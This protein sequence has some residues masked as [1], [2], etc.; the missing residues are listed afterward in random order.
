MHQAFAVK[1]APASVAPFAFRLLLFSVALFDPGRPASATDC[2][3]GHISERVTIARVYDGD[4]VRL[5]DGR[6]L[7]IIGINTPE[8]SRPGQAGE[9]FATEARTVLKQLLDSHNHTL[10]LQYGKE[11]QDHYGRQLAHAFLESGENIA[12]ALLRQGLATTLVVPPNTWGESCYLKLEEAAR[13]ARRGLWGL[14]AYQTTAGRTLSRDT[15]GFRL[16]RG[17]VNEIRYSPRAVWIDIEGPLVIRVAREDLV[18]FS[19]D[20]PENLNGRSIE[21]RGWIKQDRNGLRINVRHPAAMVT[22]A[23]VTVNH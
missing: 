12:V 10:L 21:V 16:I 19:P 17:S 2:P 3:A 14:A 5:A 7:R 11:R 15:R 4:T 6:R 9:P 20:F 23:D 13:Q 1:G 8:I 18:N 22:L